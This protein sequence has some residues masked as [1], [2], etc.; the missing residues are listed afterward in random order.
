[1]SNQLTINLPLRKRL[2]VAAI[3]ACFASAPA[4]SNPTNP[5]VVNGSASFSQNGNLLKVTNSAGAIINWNTFSIG[6]NETTR[7]EQPSAASSVLNRVLANDP[8]VLLGTLSSNGRVWLI[9]PAG[10]MV[11]Q[12]ARIDVGGFVAS[13]LNV[14]NEDFLAG[15]LNFQ[16]TP[17]AGRI[18]NSGRI[19]TPSGGSVYLIAPEVTN[20]GIISA[21][22]G[23][24]LLAA[25]QTVQLLDT[26]T[27]GVKV[28]ITGN[29]GSA[30]NLGEIVA[31]AGRIGMA[32]VL[33]K[34]SGLLNASSVT[35]EGGR[36]FLKA[37]KD[38]TL[39]A[40]SEIKADGGNAG[41]GGT[42]LA[43]ADDTT[44]VDGSVSARGGS[45]SGDGGFVETS[46]A[47][48]KVADTARIASLAPNGKAG[49][50]LIDPANYTIAASGGDITG[51]SLGTALNAGDISILSSQG[52]VNTAGN[53]DIFVNDGISW[54]SPNSLTL[55]AVRDI[56]VN[57]SI[58]NTGLGGVNLN[59]T[60][61]INIT[62]RNVSTS[63]PVAVTAANLNVVS[64]TAPALLKGASMTA[65]ISGNI[66]VT[67]SAAGAA[68]MVA[69]S[70][71]Q[72]I[73]ASGIIVQGG[74]G[75]TNNFAEISS[76]S[77]NQSISVGNAGL[78]LNGGG[79]GALDTDNYALVAQI[80]TAAT[81]QTITVNAGGFISMT[82]GSSGLSNVGS[83]HGSR[84]LIQSDGGSQQI[85]FG[86][87][88]SIFLTGGTSGSR[89]FAQIYASTGPQTISGYPTISLTG[90]ASG[91]VAGE[92][93]YAQIFGNAGQSITASAIH[94]DGGSGNSNR[95]TLEAYGTQTIDV[96][97]LGVHLKGGSAGSDNYA[98]I[99]QNSTTLGS[100]SI[101]LR[102]SG[103]V[104][105]LQGG[106]GN[107][108][109]STS[110]PDECNL[111]GVNTY[112]RGMTT[113]NNQAFIRN[114][115]GPQTIDF[116][117]G[118]ALSLTGG[119]VGLRN[120]AAINNSSTGVQTIT[121]TLG[122]FANIV[123]TGGASGGG[124]ATDT[125][126]LLPPP[127]PGSG[128]SNAVP[129]VL[130]NSQP[131]YV[132]NDAFIKA[133]NATVTTRQ[134]IR[135]GLI[136][137]SGAGN[138]TT[139]GGAY[140]TAPAQDIRASGDLLLLGGAGDSSGG[141]PTT[142][143]VITNP[144]G[145]TD[146]QLTVGG[147]LTLA[148]GTGRGSGALI[149]SRY[150]QITNVTADVAGEILAIA[151]SSSFGAIGA[152]IGSYAGNGGAVTLRAGQNISFSN[153]TLIT[154]A[155]GTPVAPMNVTLLAK[156]DIEL[157]QFAVKPLGGA[158]TLMAGW[159]GNITSPALATAA[160]GGSASGSVSMSGASIQGTGSINVK[161]YGAL[162]L[163]SISGA[164]IFGEAGGSL[165]L[166]SGAS[167]S[168][169]GTGNSLVLV[170]NTNFHNV[171]G[172]TALSAS[173]GRWTVYSADPALDTRGGLGY[174]FKQYGMS[175]GG[176]PYSGSGSGNGFIYSVAP[177]VSLSL[178][179]ATSKVYDGTTTATLSGSNF[180][181]TG[182]LDGDTIVLD[183]PT[184]GTYADKNA[185]NGKSVST[186]VSF[187]G[188][189]DGA[190]AVKAYGYQIANSFA[191][192]PDPGTTVV[193]S[194]VAT[195][196][197]NIGQITPA[198][199]TVSAAGQNKAY[200]AGT[201]ATA[202]L[203]DNRLT[204][205]VLTLAYGSAAFNN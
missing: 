175:Y 116:Q 113:S 6:A 107:G 7:F 200:D 9:N 72:T 85:T 143:A 3:S 2:I 70:G 21:P 73:S 81:S 33:V 132:R 150:D 11:G 119:S 129:A 198:P 114:N 170:A 24:V 74:P 161:A 145:S 205:D 195:A 155:A 1:M 182:A 111:G 44:Y 160:P 100:Q 52:T 136:G 35:R 121:S 31:D 169:S 166:N 69:T 82:G 67:A 27:P 45:Q 118:G 64:S 193:P 76:S 83:S 110:V 32:G 37:S 106:S 189:Y 144:N 174:N 93:N 105:E 139:F 122:N 171:S 137:L 71:S 184:S 128:L 57:Q 181:T 154:Q 59:A 173:A 186:T 88:G 89:A 99:R 90:G 146:V 202:S 86:A 203:S 117:Q 60:G 199:L 103:A 134:T 92:G 190:P 164:T 125:D 29:E 84:A 194:P 108:N 148:G 50:W 53:G 18:D 179:G 10:I 183:N 163:D 178:T 63:G 156:G 159:N 13:T 8:S 91:G 177:T 46:G 165:I 104:M 43:L 14:R 157:S 149:G 191:P 75:G 167:L 36:V 56:N 15:R 42:I 102:A 187:L 138:A 196:S 41:N 30:T 80:G 126:P 65:T 185:G 112:C 140:I 101:I 38:I 153:G 55:T 123:L 188:A 68:R 141:S 87:G 147:K 40:A 47:H 135:G 162:L 39:D 95:A 54:N 96:N 176:A 204:G 66:I 192:P 12:G 142:A 20:K 58:A 120:H 77:G 97:G 51:A 34:N 180:T 172:S 115:F 131:I 201:A 62:S 127:A 197:G 78:T 152:G 98:G 17:N 124:Q 22:N 130:P 94:L 4:W 26:G 48:V 5:Q 49:T 61:D 25:G 158:V 151:G 109:S 28:E 19:T 23:E 16:A 79:G 168:A 133:E